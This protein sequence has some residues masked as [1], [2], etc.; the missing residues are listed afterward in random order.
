MPHCGHLEDSELFSFPASSLCRA[1]PPLVGQSVSCG[2]H[3]PYTLAVAAPEPGLSWPGEDGKE[4]RV[5]DA[6]RLDR[7]DRQL[8]V[9]KALATEDQDHEHLLRAMQQ[10]MIK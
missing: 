2:C 6:R 3:G 4:P 9:K 1:K 8:I 5:L 7:Q 10:R